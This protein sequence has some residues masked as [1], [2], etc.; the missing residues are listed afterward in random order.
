MLI[1]I[2]YVVATY[3]IWLVTFVVYIFLTKHRL[4]TTNDAVSLLEKRVT[5]KSS[6]IQDSKII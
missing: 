4:K 5:E 6:G 3:V 2:E 1:G